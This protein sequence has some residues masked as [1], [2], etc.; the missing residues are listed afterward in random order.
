MD[1]GIKRTDKVDAFYQRVWAD[2]SILP[3]T[4]PLRFRTY[5][6]GGE[7]RFGK[8][9]P[10]FFFALSLTPLQF[11]KFKERIDLIH[12]RFCRFS[13]KT[14]KRLAPWHHSSEFRPLV[15]MRPKTT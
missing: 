11:P 7:T 5:T 10:G 8:I 4:E 12:E 6:Q 2:P 1:D 9:R 14:A 13:C 15:G 3:S